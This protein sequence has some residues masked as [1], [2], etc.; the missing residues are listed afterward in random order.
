MPEADGR[1]VA[2]A[3]SRPSAP[4][5]TARW[6][7]DDLPA[8]LVWGATRAALVAVAGLAPLLLGTDRTVPFFERW[9][10]WDF[11]HYWGIALWGYAGDPTGVP[12]EAF[13]PGFPALL[14]A[15]H[16]LG[17][18]H[19]SVGLAVSAAAG[20]V[21]AVALARLAV[22]EG[23]QGAGWRAVAAWSLAPAAVFLAAP[24]TEALFLGL[25]VPAWL[26]ARRGRWALAGS[27]A[28]LSCVVRVNGLFLVAALLVDLAT[29]GQQR[30]GSWWRAGWLALS[31]LP[32]LGWSAY[33]WWLTGDPMAWVTAQERGWGREL[34]WPW[35][36]WSTTWGAAFS[37]DFSSEVTW[38]FRAELVSVVLG[39]LATGW[40]LVARRWGAATWVGLNVAAL[41]TSTW[42]F[43]VPRSTLLWWPVWVAIGVAARRH[44][45]VLVGW[46]LLS[47]PVWVWWSASFVTG[48]WAG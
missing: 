30:R 38:V 41:A 15:G 40:L 13:L 32:V 4:A 12:N 18:S 44:T 2:P 34:T 45:W 36:A 17:L 31:A 46:L 27:L 8:L 9:A 11:H 35:R 3:P 23:G 42:F 47:V 25:A 24:Y 16:Q 43:S 39:V 6:G 5:Q 22:D 29:A 1:L 19:V 28:A 7:V 10:Q 26:A 20:A 37:D 21:A 33:L 14:W 48:R